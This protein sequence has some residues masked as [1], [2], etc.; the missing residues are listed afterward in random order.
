LERLPLREVK[1]KK[2]L[3]GIP[4]IDVSVISKTGE[5]EKIEKSRNRYPND[6]Y[7][8]LTVNLQ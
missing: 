4:A 6:D 3:S 7:F 8:D 2:Y 1:S 5:I